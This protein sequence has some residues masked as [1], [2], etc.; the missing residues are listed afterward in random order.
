MTVVTHRLDQMPGLNQPQRNYLIALCATI[1][2]VRGRV[3]FRNLARYST[4]SE[5]TPHRQFQ[6]CFDFPAFNQRA[7]AQ[8]TTA[9]TTLL[10][11]QDATFIRKSGKRGSATADIRSHPIASSSKLPYHATGFMK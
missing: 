8:V 7:I 5:R 9:A 6:P 4:Y 1:L 2:A 11:A 3:N 10:V